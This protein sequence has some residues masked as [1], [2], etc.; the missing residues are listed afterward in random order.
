[1]LR[2]RHPVP[3]L[4]P[5]IEPADVDPRSFGCPASPYRL[6]VASHA[7]VRLHGADLVVCGF[8]RLPWPELQQQLAGLLIAERNRARLP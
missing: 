2:R 4:I 7:P 5:P 8:C 3:G 6:L 1:V